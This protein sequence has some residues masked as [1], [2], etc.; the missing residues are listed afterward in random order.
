MALAACVTMPCRVA[1]E[2]VDGAGFDM[3][4][5]AAMGRGLCIQLIMLLSLK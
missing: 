4:I 1:D 5:T 2:A 3:V